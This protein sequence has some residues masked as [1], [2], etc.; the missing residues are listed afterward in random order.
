MIELISEKCGSLTI[1]QLMQS[2]FDFNRDSGAKTHFIGVLKGFHAVGHDVFLLALQN[3]RQVIRLKNTQTQPETK[4]LGF[5]GSRLFRLMEGGIRFVQSRLNLP[6]VGIFDSLRFKEACLNHLAGCDIFH[7]RYALMSMGGVWAAKTLAIP[8]VLEVHADIINEEM[9]LHGQPL[10]GLQHYL[11]EL[12]TRHCF[13]QAAKIV[14]VSDTVGKR[15]QSYW[16]IPAE[17]IVTVPLGADLE[18]FD[19]TLEQPDVR[20]ELG[21]S[22]EPVI[23]FTGTFQPWHGLSNLIRA[24]SQVVL[25]TPEARLVLVGDGAV[26]AEL[27]IQARAAGLADKIIFTG[28]VPYQKVSAFVSMAG[29]A[30]APYPKLATE[31]WF[32]PLKLY[33]YMAASK[34]IV[35]SRVGQIVDV[36]EDGHSGLLVEPDD[37]QALSQALVKLLKDKSLRSKLGENARCAALA[38]HSWQAHTEKLEQIY[39][40]LLPVT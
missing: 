36:L 9:P 15:L 37:I 1:G 17:K 18:L 26:R 27:E 6:Y 39:R 13:N 35:A 8:L 23:V 34:A 21:L 22:D 32:S 14:V 20:A 31:L 5:S 12:T 25:E 38:K 2:G 11:A 30:V 4:D 10:R 16:Q 7:E 28:S 19:P 33:E 3:G 40:S 24:F 29:V